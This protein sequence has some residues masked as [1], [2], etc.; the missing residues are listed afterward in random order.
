MSVN[1]C[2]IFINCVYQCLFQTGFGVNLAGELVGGCYR[3]AFAT[4]IYFDCQQKIKRLDSYNTFNGSSLMIKRFRGT[5]NGWA[6]LIMGETRR[7]ESLPINTDAEISCIDR[8]VCLFKSFCCQ[9]VNYTENTF[10][11]D[12]KN[13]F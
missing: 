2:L 3:F 9:N 1:F 8:S 11:L 12:K 10:F 4:I 7:I 13:Y 5:N 6:T